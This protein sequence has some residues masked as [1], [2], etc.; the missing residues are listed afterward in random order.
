MESVSEAWAPIAEHLSL[1]CV[2]CPRWTNPRSAGAAA[3]AAH[4]LSSPP[5]LGLHS[6]LQP[7]FEGHLGG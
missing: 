5:V 2:S 4:F 1:L 7:L 6:T 3:T